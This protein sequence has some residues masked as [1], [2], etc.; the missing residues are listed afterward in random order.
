MSELDQKNTAMGTEPLERNATGEQMPTFS[1]R[2]PFILLVMLPL[3]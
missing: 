1:L 3:G 2:L